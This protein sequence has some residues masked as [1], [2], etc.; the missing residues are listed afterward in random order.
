MSHFIVGRG[1]GEEGGRSLVKKCGTYADTDPLVDFGINNAE[2][3][4]KGADRHAHSQTQVNQALIMP[5][6]C[7][8]FQTLFCWVWVAAQ[9]WGGSIPSLTVVPVDD[10]LVFIQEDPMQLDQK[11]GRLALLGGSG[12][13]GQGGGGGGGREGRLCVCSDPVLTDGGG[14]DT[15]GGA[16]TAAAAAQ[17]RGGTARLGSVGG[18]RLACAAY[19]GTGVGGSRGRGHRGLEHGTQSRHRGRG[20]RSEEG[21]RGCLLVLRC[22]GRHS[23]RAALALGPQDHGGWWVVCRGLLRMGGERR[24]GL[25]E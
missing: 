12:G 21:G 6:V 3:Q 15:P 24:E 18:G 14:F 23:R 7:S 8:S 9:F 19:H 5:C 2:A 22:R 13:G 4:K 16:T 11:L 1:R 17:S 10:V 20:E 25:S